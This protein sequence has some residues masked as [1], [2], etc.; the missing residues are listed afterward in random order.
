MPLAMY[1][2][3]SSIKAHHLDSLNHDN[4]RSNLAAIWRSSDGILNS[5]YTCMHK[6]QPN[7]PADR[8]F[9]LCHSW[10]QH[11]KLVIVTV[12]WIQV[13][14]SISL[15]E[16][17]MKG[18]MQKGP[19]WHGLCHYPILVFNPLVIYLSIHYPWILRI[20]YSYANEFGTGGIESMPG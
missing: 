2:I 14:Y 19:L 16:D 17:I 20:L 8:F 7:F 15:K 1:Q 11:P 10:P 3:L 9:H 18:S 6:D 4:T 12:E 13:T 5:I